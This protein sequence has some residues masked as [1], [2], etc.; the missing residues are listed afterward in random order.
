MK[1]KFQISAKNCVICDKMKRNEAHSGAKIMRRG[2]G[3][4]R[5]APISAF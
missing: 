5:F 3:C 4:V 2:R 1:E